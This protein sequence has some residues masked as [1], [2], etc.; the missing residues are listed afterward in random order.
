MTDVRAEPDGLFVFSQ[1]FSLMI[2]SGISIVRSLLA[3]EQES[4]DDRW[5]QRIQDVRRDV[6]TG[7]TLSEALRRQP[8]L[9]P[10]WF[11]AVVKGGEIT[12][13][14]QPVL[15]LFAAYTRKEA[16]GRKSG[17]EPSGS[18]RELSL[19]LRRIGTLLSAGVPIT[20][21]FRL[22]V[23]S[24]VSDSLREAALL[25]VEGIIEGES[26][27][28]ELAKFPGVI[29]EVVPTLIASGEAAGDLDR[30]AFCLADYFE[31]RT[32][33]GAAPI[34]SQPPD[35]LQPLEPSSAPQPAEAGAEGAGD[36]RHFQELIAPLI[37]APVAE[38]ATDLH[39]QPGPTGLR[40]RARTGGVLHT[41]KELQDAE[42]TVL[43]SRLKMMAEMNLVEKYTPQEG[44]IDLH[45]NERE[46]RLRVN[47]FPY[48]N[49][50][51][52]HLQ[53]LEHQAAQAGLLDLG[54]TEGQR[55]ECLRLLHHPHGILAVAGRASEGV[56]RT[57][58]ALLHELEAEGVLRE[59]SAVTIEDPVESSLPGIMQVQVNRSA[60]VTASEALRS[61]M[62]QDPDIVVVGRVAGEELMKE[63]ARAA[64]FGRMVLVGIDAADAASGLELL[65]RLDAD[66]TPDQVLGVIAQRP[67]RIACPSCR[68]EGCASC[69]GVGYRGTTFISEVLAA[70][71]PEMQRL[72]HEGASR[73]E[74]AAAAARGGM[75]TLAASAAARVDAGVTT[76]E[77]AL[78]ATA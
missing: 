17:G 39:L 62:H 71:G 31:L 66:V 64:A 22:S 61:L 46:F 12:G 45:L 13:R 5:R 54:M 43:I 34:S 29:P 72:A 10:E 51:S 7:A 16:A 27:S 23:E 35:S 59:A 48:A 32:E 24:G 73:D 52:V 65:L 18:S 20:Q 49:G 6:E 25:T 3:L 67:L 53:V 38:G 57:L 40:V 33:T 2:D 30:V 15:Q 14:L 47:T 69:A 44:A 1:A 78:R 4:R 60:G 41:L 63:A 42:S 19:W 58:Y 8:D 50:E 37:L 68:G 70:D 28:K 9:F 21:T 11:A 77:E 36:P 76:A 75:M 74:I 26:V 55:A 56:S